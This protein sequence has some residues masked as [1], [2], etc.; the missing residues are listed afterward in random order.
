ML[1]DLASMDH[2]HASSLWR[3]R[4]EMKEDEL[5][6]LDFTCAGA[7][8]ERGGANSK[9]TAANRQHYVRLS[10]HHLLWQRCQ[11]GLQ[12]FIAGFFEVVPA[13][14][15]DGCPEDDGLLQLLMG[16]VEVSDDEINEL[17]KCVVPSGLV[18]TKL[19]DNH[20]VLQ[21]AS[22]VFRT[23]RE[24][25]SN[26]RTRLLEFWLGVGRVPL[27][28]L[29]S[30]Q[31]RPKLQVMVQASSSQG[32]IVRIGSWP[33]ER[34]PEGHTC[35]NELWLSLPESYEHCAAQL[36]LAVGNFEAGFAMR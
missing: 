4:H 14:L 33:K 8:L 24:S 26:F 31:P 28:G 22:W 2:I 1:S 13:Q 9:V 16:A 5:A 32:S 21:A 15:L 20:A 7:E 30:V 18:P 17:E 11:K 10:C 34:L 36:R 25:D 6:W 29:G 3:V 23:A 12:A 27:G 19:R 35:T